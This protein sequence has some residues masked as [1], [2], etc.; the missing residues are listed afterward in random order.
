MANER[1][2]PKPEPE[3]VPK[4]PTPE[5][6][7]PQPAQPEINPPIAPPSPQPGQPSQPSQP[8]GYLAS[9]PHS[10]GLR[11]FIA[12]DALD[13]RAFADAFKIKCQ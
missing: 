5:T 4:A 13:S 12:H 8:T 2:D 9:G 1:N 11:G 3:I 10:F 7:A 6:P